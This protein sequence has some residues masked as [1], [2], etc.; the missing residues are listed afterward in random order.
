MLIVICLSIL[1]IIFSD[2]MHLFKE[3]NS[4]GNKS[5]SDWLRKDYIIHEFSEDNNSQ[6]SNYEL[7]G[8]SYLGDFL[9]GIWLRIPAK[10]NE[11]RVA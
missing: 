4:F 9:E 2:C 7:G 10:F 3:K 6:R 11:W 1:S 5:S 8:F